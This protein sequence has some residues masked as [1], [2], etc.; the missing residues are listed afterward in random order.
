MGRIMANQKRPAVKVVPLRG[1]QAIRNRVVE[2]RRM[3]AADLA[4]NPRNWRT[5]PQAQAG[6]LRG[7]LG[8]VGQVGELYAY[9]SERDGGRLTLID[10]HLRQ[11]ELGPDQ[12]WDVAITDL[13]DEEADKLLLVRDPIAAMAGQSAEALDQ[14]LADVGTEDPALDSLLSSLRGDGVA[15]GEV[16]EVEVRPPPKV[17]WLLIAVPLDAWGEAQQHVAALEQVAAITVQTS[18]DG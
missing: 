12:E 11:G 7:I 1:R 16:E 4:P 2:R 18:R 13:T 6:A 5:H 8:E 9:R 17:V 10:G 15:E 14:L 3:R